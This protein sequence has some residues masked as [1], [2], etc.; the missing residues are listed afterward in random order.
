MRHDDIQAVSRA[1]AFASKLVSPSVTARAFPPVVKDGN[2][3]FMT[4]GLVNFTYDIP[5][6]EL[7]TV[8]SL[9]QISPTAAN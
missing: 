2:D 5:S 8:S 9:R 4:E 1:V 6:F 3:P 7:R